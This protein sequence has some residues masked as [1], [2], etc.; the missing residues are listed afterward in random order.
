MVRSLLLGRFGWIWILLLHLAVLAQ[1]VAAGERADRLWDLANHL[2]DKQDY[3]RA[4]TEFERFVFLFPKD[5]RN[6]QAKLQI[7]RCYRRE[8]EADKAFSS[9]IRLFNARSE[10][11][12]GPDALL[13]MIK[14]REEQG[15]YLRAIYWTKQFIDR[16]PDY[17]EIT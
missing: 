10:E 12:V 9:L 5:F 4:L 17:S 11:A 2:Y 1:P 14:I 16:Y 8:G 3:Y 7:G 6:D 15:R 13:E